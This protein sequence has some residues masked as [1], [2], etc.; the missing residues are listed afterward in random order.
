[1][2]KPKILITGSTGALGKI[3]IPKIQEKK[4]ECLGIARNASRNESNF[5]TV[6]CDVTEIDDIKSIIAEFQPSFI[7]HLAGLTGNIECEKNPKDAFVSNV[8]S[9]CNILKASI[10]IKPK[11][12]F[13][14]SRE[15]YGNTEKK[16]KEKDQ[17]KPININGI[18][19]MLSEN[20]ILN[21]HVQ[22]RMP[23]E[24]LRFTNFYGENCEKRGISA[25]IRNAM[26]GKLISIFGGKQNLDLLYFDDAA[27]AIIKAINYDKSDIFNIGSGDSTTLLS[28]VKKIEEI[29][30]KKIPFEIKPYRDFEVKKFAVDMTKSRNILK[31]RAVHHLD[32]VLKR[33]FD[34][35]ST[36]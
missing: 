30:K 33:M 12:V 31:F 11:I 5:N 34:K 16:A 28:L 17:L 18:T 36:N 14:S 19:K 15:V 27:S 7:I 26:Q 13:A 2:K 29:R 35:W 32:W 6:K 21:Y 10:K 20:L 23:Y 4:Y 25:M 9:T 1:M 3:L 8:L 22:Y 24:V